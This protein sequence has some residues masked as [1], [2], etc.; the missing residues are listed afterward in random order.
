M[1]KLDITVIK[2]DGTKEKFKPA[3]VRRALR[4]SGLSHKESNTALKLLYPKL[5]DG[6]TTRQIYSKLYSIVRGLRPEKKYRFNLKQALVKLGP[7]GYFFEDYAAKLFQF[8]GYETELRAI[9][10]GRCVTHEVDVVAKKGREKIMVECKFRNEP[11]T[12][13]RIQ[14]ALYIHA[15]FQDLA[16]GAR[17]HSKIPFTKPCLTTNAKFSSHVLK[18]AECVGMRLIGWAYPRD[19]SLEILADR[20]K[21]YP[22]SVINMKKHTLRTMLKKGFVVVQDIPENPKEL[23]KATGLSVSTARRIAKEAK[24]AR[25]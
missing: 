25:S 17:L 5:K 2:K 22:I 8:L 24:E 23:T 12:K 16:E 6:M 19:G 15:R 4:R 11:G 3:K 20:T 9:P 18:Y 14:T 10:I 13:C 21:C 7:A 1:K